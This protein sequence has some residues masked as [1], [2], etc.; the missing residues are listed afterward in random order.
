MTT[1]ECRIVVTR[2]E[3]ENYSGR[4]PSESQNSYLGKRNSREKSFRVCKG[5][6]TKAANR[7]F[8]VGT[9]GGEN[10]FLF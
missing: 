6:E 4:D 3:R 8:R 9:L 7:E 5:K 10:S 2:E 1:R